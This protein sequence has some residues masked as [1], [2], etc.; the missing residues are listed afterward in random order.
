M[1]FSSLVFLCIFLP[2]VLIL[3]RVLPTVRSRNIL[4][5]ISSLIFYAYG[6]P[7]YVLLMIASCLL[8]YLWARL[9]A[10]YQ[11]KKKLILVL[12]VIQNLSVLVVFK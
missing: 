12:A 8:N 5:L 9:I 7:V 1:V 3:N 11:A 6:E 2:I 10:A 4:L